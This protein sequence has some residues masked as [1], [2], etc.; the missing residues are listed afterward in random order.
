[1]ER[2]SDIN[3]DKKPDSSPDA[4]R[5]VPYIGSIESLL[6]PEPLACASIL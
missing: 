3:Y 4:H 2:F 1:M 5:V 6:S